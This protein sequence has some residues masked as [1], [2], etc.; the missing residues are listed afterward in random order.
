MAAPF[1]QLL[2]PEALEIFLAPLFLL[3]TLH[4]QS[5]SNYVENSATSHHF[6][7][8]VMPPSLAAICL[9]VSFLLVVCHTTI[10]GNIVKHS[11]HQGIYLLKSPHLTQGKPQFQPWPDC[12]WPGSTPP[13]LPPLHHFFFF[14][15]FPL[16]LPSCCSWETLNTLLPQG[17]CTSGPFPYT[18][19][20]TAF[21]P[22]L[23][24]T[25]A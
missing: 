5:I 25:F 21:I 4:I 1:V 11:S 3:H 18:P 23:P 6:T 12:V 7:T 14:T 24:L 13:P 22:S 2:R 19:L 8:T 15:P 17:F 9:L 10:G 20:P 16:H